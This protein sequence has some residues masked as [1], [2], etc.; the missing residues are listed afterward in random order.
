MHSTLKVGG[1]P[2]FFIFPAWSLLITS[3]RCGRM[4]HFPRL[5]DKSAHYSLNDQQNGGGGGLAPRASFCAWHW[6]YPMAHLTITAPSSPP[7]TDCTCIYHLLLIQSMRTII[8]YFTLKVLAMIPYFNFQFFPHL[9]IFLQFRD[10]SYVLNLPTK[11]FLQK[12][13]TQCK[14]AKYL[15]FE[16]IFRRT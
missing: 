5:T 15:Q 4:T 3:V 7:L 6:A 16:L 9:L 14:R 1:G 8:E 2:R 12:W 11:A 13:H 10:P